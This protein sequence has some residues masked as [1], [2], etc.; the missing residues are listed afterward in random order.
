MAELWQNVNEIRFVICPRAAVNGKASHNGIVLF[1]SSNSN[2][3]LQRLNHIQ[4]DVVYMDLLYKIQ[5][6]HISARTSLVRVTSRQPCST[7]GGRGRGGRRGRG[8]GRTLRHAA[9]N[10]SRDR[11]A[12]TRALLLCRSFL[13]TSKI[14]NR[15]CKTSE[16]YDTLIHS[17]RYW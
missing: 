4:P 5:C 10:S 15:E 6:I 11:S 8:H 14:K 13:F 12:V 17:E 3:A 16:R 1:H 9:S 2:P 7:V